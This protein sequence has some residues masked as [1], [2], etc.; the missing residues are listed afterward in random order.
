MNCKHGYTVTNPITNS[1]N[2]CWNRECASSAGNYQD[3]QPVEVRHEWDKDKEP[4]EVIQWLS[5]LLDAQVKH[6][7]CWC[8]DCLELNI[9]S[10]RAVALYRNQPTKQE[11]QP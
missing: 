3:L 8:G 10:R 7:L 2:Q 5:N 1:S 6:H 9:E 4:Q 11:V